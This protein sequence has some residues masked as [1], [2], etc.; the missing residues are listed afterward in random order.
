MFIALTGAVLC[1]VILRNL[2]RG[3]LGNFITRCICVIG[4]IDDWEYASYLY[5]T[6]VRTYYSLIIL[7][8]GTV[9][10]VI[11]FSIVLRG[12]TKCFDTMLLGVDALLDDEQTQICMPKEIAFVGEKLQSVK[13]ELNKRKQQKEEAEKRKDELIVYLAHDIKTPLTSVLGYI[14][15]LN[16][17][18]NMQPEEREK[19]TRVALDK[20]IRLEELINEFFEITKSHTQ[21]ILLE[22]SKVD[23]AYL[24]E[25][26][27][28]EAYPM[29]TDNH[30]QVE[31]D[32][33]E[34]LS[35]EIDPQKMARVIAN[36]LK[37]ACHYSE[38]EKIKIY[39]IVENDKIQIVFEN[40]GTVPEEDLKHLFEKFY[41]ADE[42]RQTK[43]GGA[44][45][46]LAISKDIVEAHG[47]SIIAECENEIFRITVT[48]YLK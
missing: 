34:E 16:D 20:A 11:I 27:I 44:G 22:K 6:N 8:I 28:D 2:V 45:L 38:D 43:T 3:H 26:V 5:L 7:C 37:N 15:L 30:K 23:L 33:S 36:L 32:L 46:G 40:K 24:I 13:E 41:R 48:L 4:D 29:L 25:Q 19:Y 47:G 18:P 10:F 39:T 9:F 31:M 17:N 14:S 42:A 12:F 1:V 35:V 21:T